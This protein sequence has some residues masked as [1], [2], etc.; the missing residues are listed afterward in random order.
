MAVVDTPFS[1]AMIAPTV[2]GPLPGSRHRQDQGSQHHRIVLRDDGRWRCCAG[3]PGAAPVAPGLSPPL[4][5][6]SLPKNSAAVR[7]G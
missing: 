2:A 1:P 6:E 3:Q 7:P 4:A 5:E